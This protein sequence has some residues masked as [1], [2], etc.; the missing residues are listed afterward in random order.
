[1]RPTSMPSRL[2]NIQNRT[3]ANMIRC[4][5]GKAVRRGAVKC[6]GPEESTGELIERLRLRND[7]AG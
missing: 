3:R 7:P 1:M 4:G 6:H 2:P 5:R